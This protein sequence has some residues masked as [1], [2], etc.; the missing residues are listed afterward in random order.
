RAA[1]NAALD[2]HD[3]HGRAAMLFS[4]G[5][6]SIALAHIA[7]PVRDQ[8]ELVWVN[9]GAM[10]PHMIE[11]VRRYGERFKL[12]ELCSDQPARLRNVG[13]PTRI[14]PFVN[15]RIGT[16][17]AREP[18]DRLRLADPGPCCAELRIK[19]VEDYRI[20]NDVTL[21]IHGQKRADGQ[22][23][24]FYT[25]P[26]ALAPLWGWT[27]E[28]VIA[29]IGAHGIALPEQYTAGEIDSLE[30]WNCTVALDPARLRWMRERYPERYREFSAMVEK[31]YA[32]VPAEW[33]TFSHAF[34][35]LHS[36]QPDP[37][38]AR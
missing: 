2:R 29:Y 24:A 16:L 36:E 10:F 17:V 30:C 22:A 37:S 15:T 19:P 31:V 11:F 4:G 33:S 18:R 12:V 7:E 32:T 26:E 14:I 20:A 27:D 25:S 3:G 35:E 34:A 8:F 23:S 9:T 28:D 21:L 38:T 6:D 13:L 1:I 5:K